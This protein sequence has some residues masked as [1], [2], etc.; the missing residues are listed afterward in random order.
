[1][2]DASVRR[3]GEALHESKYREAV[4]IYNGK[5]LGHPAREAKADPQVETAVDAI[6]ADYLSEILGYEEA[7]DDL[8]VLTGIGKSGLSWRGLSRSGAAI[9]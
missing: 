9:M 8:S 6:K 4:M 5:I 3:F 2:K 1:M 7:R